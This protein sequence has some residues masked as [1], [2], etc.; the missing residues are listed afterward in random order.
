MTKTELRIKANRRNPEF[1]ECL[2]EAKT[3]VQQGK[4]REGAYHILKHT[5]LDKKESLRSDFLFWHIPDRQLAEMLGIPNPYDSGYK[6]VWRQRQRLK[7]ERDGIEKVV[8]KVGSKVDTSTKPKFIGNGS[9]FVYLYYF[10]EYK[11]S[12]IYYIKYVDDSHEMPIY[13]CNIGKTTGDV[14]DRVSGQIGQ[15]LPEKARIALIIKTD[16]CEA[17]EKK[18]HAELKRRRK[19]LDPAFENVVGEEWFRTNPTE[20]EGIVKS[21]LK[22][23][24]TP[25]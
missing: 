21:L 19:W 8:E 14:I 2:E 20:V 1:I 15:Q 9:E 10:P 23:R 22:K 12:S 13:A 11:L 25:V 7:R 24:D 3:L 5:D 4:K 6:I 17:L 16:D 18:I